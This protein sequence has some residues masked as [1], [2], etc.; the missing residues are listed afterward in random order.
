[1]APSGYPQATKSGLRREQSQHHRVRMMTRPEFPTTP[2]TWA[3][4]SKLGISRHKFDEAVANHE[5]R[6]VLRNV[7]VRSDVPD[8]TLL[9]CQAAKLVISPFAVV[10]DRTAAWLHGV[11]VFN[12]RELEILPPLETFVLRGHTATRR[13]ECAGGKRDLTEEDIC[14]LSGLLVT[15]PLRTAMDLGCKLSRRDALAALDAF[16]RSHGITHSEMRRALHRYF[17]RRG[18][19]Q[20]RQLIPLADPRAESPGESWTR[21]EIIDAGLPIPDLQVWVN[22]DGVPT[23]RLD[24]AYAKHKVVI[25]YDGREFHEPD[26]RR[27]YDEQRRTWLRRHG[28]TVIVVDKDSFSEESLAGWLGE[29][30]AALRLAA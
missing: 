30:R 27:E 6:K 9:R 25:E 4:A 17:R 29:L 1:M 16:M 2:F 15:T 23:Y 13:P 24:L 20:L 12:Y 3:Q 19:I 7:Y 5:L 11:D 22:V 8:T 26:E 10:C 28:W 18:V 14:V 21:I